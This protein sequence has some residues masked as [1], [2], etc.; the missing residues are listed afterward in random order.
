MSAKS[1]INI[2]KTVGSITLFLEERHSFEVIIAVYDNELYICTTR[3]L[4]NKTD[5]IIHTMRLPVISR[6][7]LT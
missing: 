1:F 5:S 2:R 4:L 6:R 3:D 7:L